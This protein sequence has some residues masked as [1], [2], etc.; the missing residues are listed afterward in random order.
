ME[1]QPRSKRRLL[2]RI[3]GVVVASIAIMCFVPT[4][5]LDSS[6]ADAITPG[7]SVRDATQIVGSAPGWYDGVVVIRDALMPSTKGGGVD[8]ASTSGQL[9]LDL[10]ANERV[11]TAQFR[12][13]NT[14]VSV[15][16]FVWERTIGRWL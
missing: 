3:A 8:W 10:D 14:G 13:N 7:M 11:I 2:A 5:R 1:S 12:A 15:P 9:M 16:L 6:M 4:L